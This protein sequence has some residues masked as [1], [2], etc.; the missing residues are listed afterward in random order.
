MSSGMGITF[1]RIHLGH[2]ATQLDPFEGNDVAE[3][4]AP[5]VGKSY[6]SAGNPLSARVTQ[7]TAIDTGGVAGAAWR[8][9]RGGGGVAGALDQNNATSNDQFT[10]NIGGGGPLPRFTD[11]SASHFCCAIR[12]GPA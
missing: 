5:F 3:G 2:S 9:L 7:A 4:A 8:G 12:R 6:G 11:R 10:T 1:N